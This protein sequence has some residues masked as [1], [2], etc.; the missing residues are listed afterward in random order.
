MVIDARDGGEGPFRV[1]GSGFSNVS[2]VV[3]PGLGGSGLSS[4][5]QEDECDPNDPDETEPGEF[6]VASDNVLWIGIEAGSARGGLIR[7][8]TPLGQSAFRFYLPPSPPPT[9]PPPTPGISNQPSTINFENVF[10]GTPLVNGGTITSSGNAPLFVNIGFNNDGDP[11]PDVLSIDGGSDGLPDFFVTSQATFQLPPGET[12]G[13]SVRCEPSEAG[14]LTTTLLIQ[15]NTTQPLVAVTLNCTGVAQTPEYASNPAPG[16]PI[17]FL[18]TPGNTFANSTLAIMEMGGAALQV[19]NPQITNDPFG[20]FSVVSAFPIT[21]NDGGPSQNVTIRCTPTEVGTF[22]GT[23]TL[24][25]NDPARPTVSYPLSC[26]SAGPEFSGF[27]AENRGA[28]APTI[29]EFGSVSTSGS[30]TRLLVITNTGVAGGGAG[31]SL[32]LDPDSIDLS[33]HEFFSVTSF[34]VN[35]LELGS[36]TTIVVQCNP[37]ADGLRQATLTF[38]NTGD[39]FEPV[40]GFKY[41]LECTGF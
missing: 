3:V 18:V 31:T 20:V 23:L 5:D 6:C 28:D 2:R 25:T 1:E 16:A 15:N 19:S 33:D 38:T 37:T 34:P 22:T 39:P 26:T 11:E 27:P 35:P 14:P 10:V 40:G 41:N 8:S 32:N 29:I 9:P 21:I 24:T 12:Q 13:Y 7:V 36:I 4:L 30:V 17:N